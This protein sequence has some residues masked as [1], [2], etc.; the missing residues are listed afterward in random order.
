MKKIASQI[1]KASDVIRKRYVADVK[2]A[3]SIA[4]CKSLLN[5]GAS[6]RIKELLDQA[7][8]HVKNQILRSVQVCGDDCLTVSFE[9][10]VNNIRS[11]L[12]KASK[13]SKILA[14]KVVMCSPVRP[15]S[16]SQAGPRGDTELNDALRKTRSIVAKCKVCNH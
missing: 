8:S 11:L 16:S 7:S 15:S 12:S 5:E 4:S 13:E 3:R 10:E 2:R 9:R 14:R 1:K 6:V